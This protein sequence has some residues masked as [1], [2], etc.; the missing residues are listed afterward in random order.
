MEV[1][2]LLQQ[3][4]LFRDLTAEQLATI[5]NIIV[6]ETFLSGD[7]VFE[8]DS[9]AD[10]MYL[11]SQGQL[12]VIVEYENGKKESV[13][14]LGTGQV[15]GEMTLVDEGRRSATVISAEDET[16]VFSIPNATFTELCAT[17]TDI[18]YII[19][20]NIAQDMSFKLRHRG[21]ETIE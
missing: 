19:M 20:R 11:I 12:E 15:V 9:V 17:N 3:I 16:H 6:E 1:V 7:V 21:S 13:L 18:G 4:D 5:S 8:Q 2:T 14:Y 10:K